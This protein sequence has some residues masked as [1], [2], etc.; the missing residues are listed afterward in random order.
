MQRSE[1]RMKPS[2]RFTPALVAVLGVL[3]VLAYSINLVLGTRSVTIERASMQTE[4]FSRVLE[5]HARQTLRRVGGR[6]AQ[7]DI[8]LRP[9][10]GTG[11]LDAPLARQQLTGL[12]PDDQLIQNFLVLNRTGAVVLSTLAEPGTGNGPGAARKNAGN[13][14]VMAT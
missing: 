1:Y 5:E 8:V 3:L 14:P 13:R 6:L 4:N 12:L 2:L 11:T 9:L 10:L 7:A